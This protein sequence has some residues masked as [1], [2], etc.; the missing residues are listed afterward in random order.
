MVLED[1]QRK[2]WIEPEKLRR[3]KGPMGVLSQEEKKGGRRNG[4]IRKS[5]KE[6]EKYVGCSPCF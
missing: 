1:G 6:G 3:P 4:R 5:Q 2:G